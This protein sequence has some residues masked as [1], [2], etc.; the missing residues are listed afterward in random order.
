MAT[1]NI[2]YISLLFS[3]WSEYRTIL[4]FSG[5]TVSRSVCVCGNT[6][7]TD[8]KKIDFVGIYPLRSFLKNYIYFVYA[9]QSGIFRLSKNFL[10]KLCKA[11]R[12]LVQL[13]RR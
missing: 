13:F 5:Y 8:T 6:G 10:S 9:T 4:A 11:F 12:P 1:K 2:V 7:W 3:L